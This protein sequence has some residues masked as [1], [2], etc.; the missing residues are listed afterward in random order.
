MREFNLSDL[1]RRSGELADLALV[2]PI[3]L[4]K[5]GRPHLVLLS[6][7]EYERLL[8]PRNQPG[9]VQKALAKTL[10]GPKFADLTRTANGEEH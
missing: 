6:A 2:A 5:H 9:G 10:P 1:N 4:K 8:A 7:A 3:S